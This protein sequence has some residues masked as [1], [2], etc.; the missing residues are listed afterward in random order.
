MLRRL[1]FLRHK[2][3]KTRYNLVMLRILRISTMVSQTKLKSYETTTS[4]VVGTGIFITSFFFNKQSVVGSMLPFFVLLRVGHIFNDE[5][6][7]VTL[8]VYSL[9]Q[10]KTTYGNVSVQNGG[11]KMYQKLRYCKNYFMN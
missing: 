10:A 9:R 2:I 1:H 4:K 3:K 11:E 5:L 7:L 8:L 6:V